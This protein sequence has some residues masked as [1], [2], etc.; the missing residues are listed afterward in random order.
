MKL[1][2]S[3]FL[4]LLI[5]AHGSAAAD[6]ALGH[7]LSMFRDGPDAWLGHGLFAVLLLCGV[8]YTVALVR[9]RREGEAVV[10]GFA[11]L[12]LLVV[13]ATPSAGTLHGLCSFLLLL[14]LF[15]HYT[16]LLRRAGGPWVLAHLVVPVA[17]VLATRFHSYGLWQKGLILYFLAAV[18]LHHH[19]LMRQAADAARTGRR[20]APLRRR[21]VYQLVPGRSWSKR[22]IA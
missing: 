14:L 17:L 10:S 8:L 16:W 18:V 22:R 1:T 15:A 13:A 4:L 2:F 6:K 20:A 9:C 7:P 5:Y 12:L 19:F 11:V 3:A 21:T